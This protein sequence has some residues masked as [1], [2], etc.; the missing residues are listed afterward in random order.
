[1]W[2]FVQHNLQ[3]LLTKVLFYGRNYYVANIMDAF[4]DEAHADELEAFVRANLPAGAAPV[5]A[6][7][8]DAM[9]HRAIIKRRELPVID[10]WIKS[11][12]YTG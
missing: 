11:R 8:A 5:A 10:N 1:V 6:R 4:S 12:G 3:P 9:R 2:D 7:T